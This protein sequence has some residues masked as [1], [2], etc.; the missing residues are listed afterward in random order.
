[1]IVAGGGVGR[2]LPVRVIV[3]VAF[4]AKDRVIVVGGVVGGLLPVRVIV[5]ADGVGGVGYPYELV[6]VEDYIIVRLGRAQTL[7]AFGF[8]TIS[9][10]RGA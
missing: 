5:A 2:V 7:R 1:M 6:P 9:S 10:L 4:L 3:G 8:T